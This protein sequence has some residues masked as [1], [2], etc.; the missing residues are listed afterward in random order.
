MSVIKR[1]VCSSCKNVREVSQQVK[2]KDMQPCLVCGSKDR[3]YD[4]K[5]T[6]RLTL[7]DE[8]GK[9]FRYNK[10]YSIL[11]AEAVAHEALMK[12]SKARGDLQYKDVPYTFEMG[13]AF[14]ETLLAAKMG[15]N[16]ITDGTGK[17]Y[18][19]RLNFH[20]KPY[21]KGVDIRLL[22][23]TDVE[24]YRS[25]RFASTPTPKPASI[26]R[27]IATLKR[28]TSLLYKRRLIKHDPLD[29]IEMLKENNKREQVL[30]PNQIE[31]M[32]TE[33]DRIAWSP[34]LKKD[35][36]VYPAHL[37]IAVLIALN[38]GLRI[39]GVL[40]LKWEEVDWD[41]REIKKIV[42]GGKEV[43]VPMSPTLHEALLAW[44]QGRNPVGVYILPSPV[45]PGKPMLITSK[46]GFQRLC[47]ALGLDDFTFHQ[48]RHTFATYFISHTKN[49]NLCAQIL[50]HSTTQMTQRYSHVIDGEA[51]AAMDTFTI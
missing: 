48:L 3:V 46:F 9:P 18:L 13:A 42:K 35:F 33:C 37:K 15:D 44:R 27:E 38:T 1:L 28:M 40:T 47:K 51:K 29:G 32:L 19:S 25:I 22:T 4:A 39:D 11:K 7:K 36:A 5:W 21:F 10:A 24:K 50:G 6:V 26:N 43:R 34:R 20:L 8:N 41:R 17:M 12:T 49:I 14:F 31:T 16:T 30:T 23:E 45:I 2:P